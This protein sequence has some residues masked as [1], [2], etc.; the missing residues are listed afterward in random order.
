MLSSSFHLVYS[1]LLMSEGNVIHIG[2]ITANLKNG[3]I[4]KDKVK[5][6]YFIDGIWI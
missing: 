1:E 2:H 5:T 4:L 6:T 3:I